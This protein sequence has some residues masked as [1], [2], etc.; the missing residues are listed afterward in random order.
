MNAYQQLLELAK[1]EIDEREG[2]CICFALDNAMDYY[3]RD[4]TWDTGRA[5]KAYIANE[6]DGDTETLYSWLKMRCI[7]LD[8]PHM[9]LARM[10]WI[11]KMI[12]QFGEEK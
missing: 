1:Q 11:D 12:E 4:I 3:N 2:Q 8:P 6:L 9:Q 10:A 7:K 5:I